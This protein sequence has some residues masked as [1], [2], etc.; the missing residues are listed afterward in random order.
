MGQG[1]KNIRF[2]KK[3]KS[4]AFLL[5]LAVFCAFL[6]LSEVNAA[7]ISK[8]VYI[9]PYLGDIDGAIDPGWYAFY[10]NL[11]DFYISNEIPI[12]I[13]F[14][15]GSISQNSSFMTPFLQMHNASNIELIQKGYLGD[16]L[17]ANMDKLSL[18]QQKEII[19]K[20][21]KAFIANIKMRE[22]ENASIKLPITYDQFHGRFTNT[23]LQATRLLGFRQYFDVFYEDDLGPI[24]SPPDY[25]VIQYG[26]SFNADSILGAATTY[27]SAEA[28]LEEIST[29]NRL[30]V[31]LKKINGTVVIPLWAHQQDFRI[32]EQSS[33]INETKW[34]TYKEVIL[35][36]KENPNVTLI[37]PTQAY[38][39]SHDTLIPPVNDTNST[40]LN[41]TEFICQYASSA[42]STSENPLGSKAVY[43]LGAPDAP[44]RNTCSAWSGYGFSWSPSSWGITANLTLTYPQPVYA[45]NLTVFGDFDMCWSGAWLENS[46]TREK[47]YISNSES[48]SCVLTNNLAGDFLADKII[49]QTCGYS[50]SSTDAVQ[51]CGATSNQTNPPIP[52]VNLTLAEPEI[53]TWKGCKE[54]AI[55]VAVD[56]FY[57][58]CMNELE[59]HGYRGTYFLS[60]T[61]VYSQQLWNTFD[62][63]FKKGHEIGTHTQEH[64]C[65]SQPDSYFYNDVEK[66]I[67]DI[68]NHTS[69]QRKD[70]ISHAQP[71]GFIT[72]NISRII[73]SNWNFLSLRGYNFNQLEDAT[74]QDFFQL[75]SFNSK[76][77]P[78]GTL[79]PPTYAQVIQG[80]QTEGKWGILTFHN[81]CND[82][83]IINA[84]PATNL[85]VDTIGSVTKYIRLRD[86]AQISDYFQASKE[87]RFKVNAQQSN[88]IYN[89]SITIK[90]P[91]DDMEASSVLV[92]GK[93]HQYQAITDSQGNALILDVA[94][95]VNHDIIVTLK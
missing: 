85:W 55:S 3:Y 56:D 65:I 41:S 93:L 73:S 27:K 48:N 35:A 19:L 89:Q 60:N 16:D 82:E 83:G 70:L 79:E 32:S 90:V 39:L 75:K 10:Q 95:P 24:Q 29:F 53:C 62:Q 1:V 18:D 49:L 12:G 66:N 54:G 86:S 42:S 81:E 6:T 80:A 34:K 45:S 91:L 43:A 36:L 51:M 17:E 23:T 78:G 25:D 28:I 94:F 33:A 15:P 14:Y 72:Q 22:G 69:V 58:S 50:W 76:S 40:D 92:D 20:G 21:Q 67:I 4:S 9:I 61:N 5:I 13:S 52:P 30:D 63:A 87:I 77:F 71:C 57:P 26:I 7:T 37:T 8:K 44:N 59:S 64:W 68:T 84:L 47:K 46:K 88:S 2:N 74:P 38:D 31:P 11:T